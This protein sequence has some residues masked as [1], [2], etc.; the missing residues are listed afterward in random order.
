MVEVQQLG[1][2]EIGR[3]NSQMNRYDE[4]QKKLDEIMKGIE[5]GEEEPNEV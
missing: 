3:L 5:V 1:D 4:I 2:E